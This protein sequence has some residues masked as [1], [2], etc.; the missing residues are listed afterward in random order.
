MKLNQKIIERRRILSISILLLVFLF[1]IV[2]PKISD[3]INNSVE[4]VFVKVNGEGVVD[5][6]IVIIKITE[7]DISALG[8]WPL[9]RSYY[10]LLLNKLNKFNVSKI[11]L[12]IF[13]ASNNSNQKIYNS[14]IINEIKERNNIVLSAIVNSL[15]KRDDKYFAE[16]LLLPELKTEYPESKIGHINFVDVNGYI[17]P[18]KIIVAE[19]EINSFSQMLVENQKDGELK[20]NFYSSFE[21]FNSYSLLEFFAASENNPTLKDKLKNKI[22]LIGVTDPT[23]GKSVS[24]PFNDVLAGIGIHAFAVDNI[25]TNRNLNNTYYNY[26][27]IFFSLIILISILTLKKYQLYFY[28]GAAIVLLFLSHLLFSLYFLELYYSAFIIPLV[29]LILFEL[30]ILFAER[31]V[32]LN[33]V[34]SENEIL[35]KALSTK[36]SKLVL[37]ERELS[38]TNEPPIELQNKIEQLKEEIHQIK[39][40]NELNETPHQIGSENER[41]NFFGIIYA[42]AAIESIVK[43]ILKVAP[44]DATVLISGDSGSGKELVANAIHSLSKRSRKEIIAFNCA[45]IPENL[46]ESEL[47]GHVKGAFT[48]ASKDKIGRFEAAN[49]G[50]IFLDEIGETSEKFQTKLLRVLQSG[51]FQ[52]VGSTETQKVD[53][54]VIAASNKDLAEQVNQNN[55][56]E[57]LYYR[58]NVITIEVP[59]LNKRKEDIPFLAEYFA[60]K[61]AEGLQISAA[62]MSVLQENSWK[63]NVRELESSIK[64]AAIFAKSEGRNIIQLCD[65]P[66]NLAKSGRTDLR[67]LILNS[68]REKGFSHSAISETAKELGNISRTIVSE[69]FRGIFFEEYVNANYNFNQAVST[70]AD[71]EQKEIVEKIKKKGETYLINIEKDL[72]KLESSSFEE[73]K[74][75][76]VSKYKNLPQKYHIYL[77]EI[78]QRTIN[79]LKHITPSVQF[80]NKNYK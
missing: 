15:E 73:V 55:F 24:T 30:F 75:E 35:L 64:R 29:S 65:I 76:F 10:A 28:S 52:K 22:I 42:G 72:V 23:I 60:N 77:D 11:G 61:E 26:S 18:Q 16:S 27:L 56:R 13:L 44:T 71:S 5:S 66:D 38:K 41:K 14:L 62:V 70:I 47:F 25:L 53:V 43:V 68:L 79:N 37:L 20:I 31:E 7:K 59:N 12:E 17:I 36:E 49:N 48:D 9:K 1:I 45:A 46:L 19:N 2:S 39:L 63:G 51:E 8:G 50:T 21:K 57:D 80:P 58:L 6:N 32:E 40:S 33:S 78:I 3:S 34:F 74:R 54:R 69:N 67:L 4:S